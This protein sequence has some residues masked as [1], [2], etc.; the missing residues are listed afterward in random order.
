MVPVILT[1]FLILLFLAHE[2]NYS[3]LYIGYNMLI[4]W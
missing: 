2:K 1:I 3:Y 4:T